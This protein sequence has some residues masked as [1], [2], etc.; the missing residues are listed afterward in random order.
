MRLW[1]EKY[2]R[3]PRL[4]RRSR[5]KTLRETKTFKSSYIDGELEKNECTGPGKMHPQKTV[6]GP[7]ALKPA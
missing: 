4:L 5:G 1:A 7:G 6:R 2:N 3:N